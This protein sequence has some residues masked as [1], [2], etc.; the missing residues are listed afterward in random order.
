M[1]EL[2]PCPHCG[3]PAIIRHASMYAVCCTH[4]HA[5]TA[6]V[7]REE[8]DAV[9]AWNHRALPPGDGALR[10]ALEKARTLIV[11]MDDW[12]K[13]VEKTI[14]K[15]PNTGFERAGYILADIRAALSRP[16]ETQGDE[17]KRWRCQECKRTD[18]TESETM[19]DNG[20]SLEG[21][22]GH[23]VKDGTWPHW[24][25]PVEP[26]QPA[27]TPPSEPARKVSDE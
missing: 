24:C 14:G 21:V 23:L 19:L 10:E 7:Y 5:E 17:P 27:E 8:D 12:N 6:L 20:V 9:I 3:S 22:L 4:C 1:S 2:L 13:A 16:A 15:V 26:T 25:G 11:A 18:I